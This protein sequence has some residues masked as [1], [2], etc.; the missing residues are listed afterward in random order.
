M[1]SEL[2][3]KTCWKICIS[4]RSCFINIQNRVQ[5]KHKWAGSNS[6]SNIGPFKNTAQLTIW[7]IYKKTCLPSK[8][9]VIN[10]GSTFAPLHTCNAPEIYTPPQPELKLTSKSCILCGKKSRAGQQVS[11][12]AAQR[13]GKAHS[14]CRTTWSYRVG[15]TCKCVSAQRWR[16]LK[17][18]ISAC[19][20]VLGFVVMQFTCSQSEMH[21]SLL[22]LASIPFLSSLSRATLAAI[23]CKIA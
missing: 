19:C 2:W 7:Y 15:S 22:L 14:Y 18:R 4:L 16:G 9:S 3:R 6:W 21:F 1:T 23:S 11:S 13:L 5:R 12:L 17:A 8:N 20:G 10:R